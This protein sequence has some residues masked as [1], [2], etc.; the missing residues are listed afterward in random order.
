MSAD[1]KI[2]LAYLVTH[3]IQYQASLLKCIASDPSIELKVFFCSDLSL[4]TYKDQGFGVPVQWDIPL[5]DGYEHEFLP[6]IGN[7]KK[8]SFF[9]PFNYGLFK[10][11]KQGHSDVVW[12]HCY[13]RWINWM[14]ILFACVLDIKVLIRD[15][16]T[17]VSAKR[18]RLKRAMKK[19]FFFVLNKMADGFLAIGSLNKQYYRSYNIPEQKIF[20][21]PYTVD[22]DFLQLKIQRAHSRQQILRDALHLEANRSVILFAS[23]MT[24]RKC[25]GDL[26][27]AY[28]RLS[29]DGKQEPLP[30]LLFIGDGEE[31]SKLEERVRQL[32]WSTV[33]IL[34]FKNQTELPAF[35]DLADVFVLPSYDEPWGL[36]INEA[37]NAGCAIVASREVGAAGD[38]VKEGKNG[39][40]FQ[41]G[42]I[43]DLAEA[44][45]K[46]LIHAQAFGEESMK[47][48]QHW[49]FRE[50]MMGLKQ[51]C[52][53][54]VSADV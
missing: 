31:K 39:F 42:D 13:A 15:E 6:A 7:T 4:S 41:A 34:G 44:L 16:A 53:E 11:L 48:I 20:S 37:M 46:T 30:Y 43:S 51:A 26:L 47:L 24:P 17:C 35:Y 22:N 45:Q 28:I 25:A 32:S 23:K 3:P 38:L 52:E 29:P 18:S 21:A 54:L 50:T 10:R 12:I 9:R 49:S 8:L 5:L 2:R 14:A 19:V 1:R 40:L 36:V 33:R 27:E